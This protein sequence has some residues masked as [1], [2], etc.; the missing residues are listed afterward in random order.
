VQELRERLWDIS[1]KRKEEDEK[2]RAKLMGDGWLEEHTAV[3]INHHSVL[4]QVTPLVMWPFQCSPLKAH[5]IHL[6]VPFP[7]LPLVESLCLRRSG[8]CVFYAL[9]PFDLQKA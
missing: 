9:L 2:E 4:M 8:L 5:A 6:L 3:L 7:W 1:D